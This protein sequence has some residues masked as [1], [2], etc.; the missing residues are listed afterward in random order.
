MRRRLFLVLGLFLGLV[1]TVSTLD[2]RQK[3]SK[4][5]TGKQD[6]IDGTV[7][8][9]DKATKIVTVRV[10]G[11]TDQRQV[12]FDDKTSITYRNKPATLD[13]LK[14]GRRVIV[15]GKFN[16]KAQLIATRIDVR[17]QQ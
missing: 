16:D 15:L 6:R 12:V 2:A 5:A 14:E 13:E 7:H 4:S 1:L 8:M 3:D 10:R 17:D 11:K 9:I